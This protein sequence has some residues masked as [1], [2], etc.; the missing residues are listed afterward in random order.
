[1]ADRLHLAVVPVEH[2]PA[3]A[4]EFVAEARARKEPWL[5]LDVPE[6]VVPLE[7]L[8]KRA[9]GRLDVAVKSRHRKRADGGTFSVITDPDGNRVELRVPRR[10][11]IEI[12]AGSG[13][14][15]GVR[16]EPLENRTEL[17]AA[18][19]AARERLRRRLLLAEGLDPRTG[20]LGA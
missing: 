11:P 4:E 10:E 5:V 2:T 17:V 3:G 14:E 6:Q 7:E 18:F 19:G 8:E 13:A 12:D 1:V 15:I 16:G 9:K 20:Q